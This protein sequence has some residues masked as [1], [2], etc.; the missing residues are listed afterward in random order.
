M[1]NCNVINSDIK[2]IGAIREQLLKEA[3]DLLERELSNN[4]PSQSKQEL[5]QTQ[6]SNPDDCEEYCIDAQIFKTSLSKEAGK[7]KKLNNKLIKK[8]V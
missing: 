5:G 4:T 7:T 8:T 6:Q 3:N 2:D 1:D